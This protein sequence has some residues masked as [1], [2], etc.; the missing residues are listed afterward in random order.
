[1]FYLKLGSTFDE[2]ESENATPMIGFEAPVRKSYQFWKDELGS[3]PITEFYIPLSDA[4]KSFVWKRIKLD[5]PNSRIDPFKLYDFVHDDIF[6]KVQSFQIIVVKQHTLPELSDEQAL[7]VKNSLNAELSCSGILQ[8]KR[9]L[10]YLS[11]SMK[12]YQSGASFYAPYTSL[13]QS[14][15][16]G[17]TRGA[18]DCGFRLAT[19]YGVFRKCGETNFPQQSKWIL[20]FI[21][22]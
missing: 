14:S 17:K 6:Y 8:A 20:H 11:A 3:R 9:I 1:M 18:I 15:G 19:I 16:F 13:C 7:P 21:N 22:I 2:F 12:I 5:K 4:S 10:K